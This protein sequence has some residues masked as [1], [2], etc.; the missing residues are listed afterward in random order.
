MD[1]TFALLQT[2]EIGK[3]V[4]QLK[5]V[6]KDHQKAA[7]LVNDIL[8]GWKE[9]AAKEA[10]KRKREHPG[11]APEDNLPGTPEKKAKLTS[12]APSSSTPTSVTPTPSVAL[13]PAPT[14]SAPAHSL[15]R[16]FINRIT[17]SLKQ[18]PSTLIETQTR[19]SFDTAVLIEAA[20]FEHFKNNADEDYK[21]Q[22]RQINYQLKQNLQL[23]ERVALSQIEPEKVGKAHANDLVSDEAKAEAARIA[24][25]V[26]EARKPIQLEANCSTE[27][28]KKCNGS[29]IH[30]RQAQ[31]RSSD[32]PMTQFFTCLDCKLKW[33]K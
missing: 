16:D 5:K 31:T 28:C 6:V 1:M 8:A 26:T 3:V 25:E 29:N 22:L 11:S 4:N 30:V 21:T 20:A 33:K 10:A 19:A 9:I 17:E 14:L 18:L 15:R 12:E 2:S 13:G 27:I 7:E 23:R 24:A 32:E